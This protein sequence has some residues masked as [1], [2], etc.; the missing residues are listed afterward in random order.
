MPHRAASMFRPDEDW[1]YEEAALL[2]QSAKFPFEVDRV[3]YEDCIE[4]MRQIPS[5]SVDMLIADPPFG[6]SFSGRE[7]IYNRDSGLVAEGYQEIEG[8][9]ED[10]TKRWTHEVP[11]VLRRTGSAWIFSGWT[12]LREVLNA[13]SQSGLK[14]INHIIWRYQFGV[15]TRKKFVTSHYHLLFLVK[16]VNNYYFNKIQHYPLDVWDI[17][18]TYRRGTTKNGTKLPEE[19]VIRCIDFATRPGALVLDPFMGNGTTAVA[20]KG[21]FRHYLGFEINPSMRD[22]ICRN[23]SAVEV[24]QFYTPYSERS[25]ELVELARRKFGQESKTE[26]VI[27]EDYKY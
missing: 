7:P 13:V 14:L 25:D 2:F 6:I 21:T 24:G 20:A 10:F 17:K 18:R 26:D 9:Y 23:L 19:L 16:D 1:T 5:E 27:S 11:R 8:D 4:G 3:L 22:V 12:H 15:F